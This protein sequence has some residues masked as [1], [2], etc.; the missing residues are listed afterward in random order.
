VPPW[1]T[2]RVPSDASRGICT[3]YCQT[4]FG[5]TW[6]RPASSSSLEK[7]S[8]WKFT[9]SVSRKTAQP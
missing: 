6:A 3:T 2:K 4:F 1:S 8:F 5:S 7:P 9:R